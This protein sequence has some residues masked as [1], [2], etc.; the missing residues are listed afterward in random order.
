M[1]LSLR[2]RKF[3]ILQFLTSLLFFTPVIVLFWQENGL[4][5]TQIMLLQSWFSFL[6][7]ALD[8]P[9]GLFSDHY[10]RKHAIIISTIFFLLGC[11]IFSAGKNFLDFFIAEGCL[12]IGVCFFSGTGSAFLYDTLLSYGKEDTYKIVEGKSTFISYASIAIASIIGGLIAKISYRH[13]FFFMI[14]FFSAAV[15]VSLLLKEP[16]RHKKIYKYSIFTRIKKIAKFSLFENSELRILILYSSLLLIFD[17]YA[18]WFFQPYFKILNIPIAAFGVIFAI[19]NIIIAISAKYAH[20]IESAIGK[21]LSLNI[22]GFMMA[23]SLIAMG[24]FLFF[25]SFLFVFLIEFVRGFSK[26]VITDYINKIVWSD[27][28]ATVISLRNTIRRLVFSITSPFIGLFGDK[29]GIP[30]TY[31]FL[32]LVLALFSV[33]FC[34]KMKKFK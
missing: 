15:I 8:I 12:A 20:K 19:L 32:G 34:L 31:F 13:T 28:R 26:P 5:L 2:I 33:F 23:L 22:L 9:T 30:K 7:V 25:F 27:K 10:G 18:V 21:K 1:E 14:P 11:I 17:A 24:K 3:Y 29:F 6:V 4:S 16:R